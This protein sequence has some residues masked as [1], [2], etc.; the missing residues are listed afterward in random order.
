MRKVI[1]TNVVSLDGFFAKPDGMP[2]DLRAT[3]TEFDDYNETRARAASTLL[4]GS[5]SFLGFREHYGAVP[6]DPAAAAPDRLFAELFSAMEK[7]VVSDSLPERI[8]GPWA[9]TR[10]VRRADARAAV[11]EM[12]AGD[13]DD[14]L[15]VASHLLWNDLLA[16]G[17]VDE[18]HVTIAPDVIGGGVP[19]FTGGYAARMRLLDVTPYPGSDAVLIRYAPLVAA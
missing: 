11:A 18:L 7:V 1:V 3:G 4:L 17:L 12:R 13:G 2:P 6:H 15:V 16:A 19:L 10:V 8:D 9:D 14:I 5:E